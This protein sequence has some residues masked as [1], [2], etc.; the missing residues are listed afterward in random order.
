MFHML[1]SI[2]DSL[3]RIASR[4][5]SARMAF[6]RDTTLPPRS[7]LFL[8]LVLSPLPMSPHRIC[9][10]MRGAVGRRPLPEMNSSLLGKTLLQMAGRLLLLF[11]NCIGS[12]LIQALCSPARLTGSRLGRMRIPLHIHAPVSMLTH[13]NSSMFFAVEQKV[14]MGA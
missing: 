13:C 8:L 10:R 9:S 4:L 7:I 12:I 1:L 6:V 14:C 3:I 11:L 2:L 5:C